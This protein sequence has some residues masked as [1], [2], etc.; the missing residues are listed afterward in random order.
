MVMSLTPATLLGKQINLILTYAKSLNCVH[1]FRTLRTVARQAPL[2]WDFPG[3]STAVGCHFLLQGIFPTQGSN[4]RLLHLLH[5]QVDSLSPCHLG[6]PIALT[7]LSYFTHFP[8][9]C[10]L[11]ICTL[12]SL[13]AL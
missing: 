4:P 12:P 3:N 6:S 9:F 8:Y 1:L 10:T 13:S 2:S 5:W 11:L 7:I